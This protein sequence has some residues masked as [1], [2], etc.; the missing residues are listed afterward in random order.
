[1]VGTIVVCFATGVA[2]AFCLSGENE[3]CKENGLPLI[4]LERATH[5]AAENGQ[6][7]ANYTMSII[8]YGAREHTKKLIYNVLY[9]E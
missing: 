2:V 9:V 3:Q 7:G 6:P 1:M 4:L 8:T 5:N